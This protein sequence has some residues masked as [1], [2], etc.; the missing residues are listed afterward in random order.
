MSRYGIDL[1][2]L[3]IWNADLVRR[4]KKIVEQLELTTKYQKEIIS[5]TQDKIVHRE[6]DRQ[7]TLEIE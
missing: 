5:I 2:N 1:V 7:D 4:G 3:N 6:A